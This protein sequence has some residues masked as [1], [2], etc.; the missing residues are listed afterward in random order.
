MTSTIKAQIFQAPSPGGGFRESFAVH[1]VLAYFYQQTA[2]PDENVRLQLAIIDVLS[3]ICDMDNQLCEGLRPTGT[4]LK[5]CGTAG[6]P[7]GKRRKQTSTCI[8]GETGL[9]NSN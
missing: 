4:W 9:L 5:Y 8:S 3:K 1:P 6:K 2:G 7:G